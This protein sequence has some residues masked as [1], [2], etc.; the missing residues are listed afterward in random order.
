MTL[1]KS[2]R[3]RG[4][5]DHDDG[6]GGVACQQERGY[7][8]PRGVKLIAQRTHQS[9]TV[10]SLN[11]LPSPLPPRNHAVRRRPARQRNGVAR[12]SSWSPLPYERL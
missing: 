5:L 11:G 8:R 10:A 9:T 2:E 3:L 1:T 6:A 12:A 4:A 7:L